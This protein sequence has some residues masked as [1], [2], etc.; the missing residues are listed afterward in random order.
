MTQ[1]VTD[2]NEW[3]KE[4]LDGAFAA[5]VSTTWDLFTSLDDNVFLQTL[6]NIV[7]NDIQGG[8]GFG[9]CSASSALVPVAYRSATL[10]PETFGSNYTQT[11]GKVRDAV[12]GGID[13][14]GL[15]SPVVDPLSFNATGVLST[16]GQAFG[17]MMFAAWKAWLGIWTHSSQCGC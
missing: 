17:L 6:D 13:E 2:L 9:D 8:N 3:T 11:A 14:M 15:L 4:I 1:Q 10:F 7:P 12:I 16:E 5:R